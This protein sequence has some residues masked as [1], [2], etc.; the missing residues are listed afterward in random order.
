MRSLPTLG[1]LFPHP[2]GPGFEAAWLDRW[3]RRVAALAIWLLV[4]AC[5]DAGTQIVLRM[6]DS[7]RGVPGSARPIAMRGV[8][9]LARQDVRL[10]AQQA[11]ARAPASQRFRLLGVIGGGRESGAALIGVDGRPAQAYPV[12]AEVAPGVRL[13]STGFGRVELEHD[14]HVRVL[15]AEQAGAGSAATPATPATRN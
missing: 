10:F 1:N 9:E 5:A 6:L 2:T 3:S 13:L 4:F 11:A 12:G 8:D 15:D 14:G 7:V